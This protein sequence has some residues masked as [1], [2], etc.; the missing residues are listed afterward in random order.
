MKP[1]LLPAVTLSKLLYIYTCPQET[2]ISNN[3]FA[4]TF[5]SASVIWGLIG[6]GRL[7]GPGMPYRPML[8]FFLIGFLLPIPFWLLSRKYPRVTWLKYVHIP[9]I[10][11]ATGMMPP[12]VPVNFS[13]WCA[14]GFIFMFYLRRYRHEWW[15]KYNYV[16]SAAFD[17]G[18]A[19]STLVIFGV[20]QGSGYVPDWWGNGGQGLYATPDNCPLASA[21]VSNVCTIC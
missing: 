8:W 6:P 1:I 2:R 16:T 21:N 15:R 4:R 12:A 19:I 9:L 11:N 20:I 3:S 7:F 14:V 5:F 10:F 13:M 17:S 18:V